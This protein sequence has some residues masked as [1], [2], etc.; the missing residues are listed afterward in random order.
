LGKL[1]RHRH[2]ELA[3]QEGC[4]RARDQRDGQARITVEETELRNH[5]EGRQNANLDGQHEREEDHP[6]RD[7][8]AREAEID[9]CESRQQ[10]KCDTAILPTAIRAATTKELSNM[11][12][13]GGAPAL[14]T[15][16]DNTPA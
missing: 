8:P 15:P 6:E 12:A 10:D 9:D 3:E 11:P 4:R 13:I 16:C 14:E 5:L 2:E 1:V 7:N